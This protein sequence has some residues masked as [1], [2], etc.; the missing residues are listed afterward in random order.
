MDRARSVMKKGK[1]HEVIIGL[2]LAVYIVS[3]VHTPVG[4]GATLN[5]TLGKV[6]IAAL[7]IG[8][9]FVFDPVVAILFALSAFEL[10][11]RN[12]VKSAFELSSILQSEEGKSAQLAAYNA[13]DEN[14]GTLEEEIVKNMAPLTGESVGAASYSGV[15]SEGPDFSSLH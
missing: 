14:N 5:T 7:A 11:R 8:S 15:M 9:F 10:V 6:I 1:E 2:V 12:K 3:G 13:R 4:L